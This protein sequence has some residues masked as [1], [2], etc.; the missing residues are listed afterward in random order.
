MILA[1]VFAALTCSAAFPQEPLL[2]VAEKS[3]FRSTSTHRD[4]MDFIS[5]L[6]KKS[7]LIKKET[8]AFSTEGREIPLLIIADPMPGSPADLKNDQRIVVYIQANIHAGEVE[9]KEAALM[10]ARDI[11]KEKKPALLRNAV[12][13]ICPIFNADGNDQISTTNRTNQNGPEN[14]VGVRHN[15]MFLDLNRDGMKAE[16]PEVKGVL[17]N[18]FNR[19]D[20]DV[21][22]D[23]HTTNGS[24]HVEPVTF[25]WMVNPNGNRQLISYMR[26]RMCPAI[27]SILS[28]KYKVEN[29]FYGEFIS[30]TEPEKGWVFDASEPRYMTNYA[31]LRNRLS[32]LNEN[33]VYADF[34]SRVLGNYW[35]LYSLLDYASANRQEILS[36]LAET[37]RSTV[38]RGE[39]PS[40]TDSLAIEYKVMPASEKAKIRTY[41]ADI[42]TDANGRRSYKRSDRQKD[43]IVPYLVDYYASKNVKFPFAYILTVKDPEVITLLRN[44]GI[45]IEKLSTSVSISAERFDISE[46]KASARL[47]QGHYTNTVKGAW[48]HVTADFPA[49]TLVIRTSQKLANVAAY[50]LEPQTNDGFLYWNFF[51]RY[52]APQWGMGYNPYP[53]YKINEKSDLRTE[54]F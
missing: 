16:S 52:L 1:A 14:G 12:I 15:G 30:M 34:K 6:L 7:K 28:D 3:E 10:F 43:V 35:L 39:N 44:H 47:N 33:Y 22:M 36:L 20:P 17:A 19:W 4:V 54:V 8:I 26:D 38:A 25:T 42:V 9:G 48:K 46:I 5:V 18:V 32:I 24:Y 31:G 23:C 27:S 45:S 21:F 11:L 2:T 50:L 37:D 41:E 29:C 40:V 51:D 53:V 49:G 13:L